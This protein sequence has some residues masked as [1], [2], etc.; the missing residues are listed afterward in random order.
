MVKYE[1]IR[2]SIRESNRLIF[3]Y[4]SK[5][6]LLVVD[7]SKSSSRKKLLKT[8]YNGKLYR[9]SITFHTGNKLGQGGPV[10]VHCRTFEIDNK[11]ITKINEKQNGIVWFGRKWLETR[12][13]WDEIWLDI[14]IEQLIEGMK[15]SFGIKMFDT[16]Y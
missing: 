1:T 11:V 4:D 8:K 15:F 7:S 9:L 5:G 13:K 10:A 12:R 2:D 6:K 3:W 16:I 14:I